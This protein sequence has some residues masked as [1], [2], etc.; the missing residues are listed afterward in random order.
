MNTL[1][2]LNPHQD[3]TPW[4]WA[5]HHHAATT[6]AADSAPR[7][8]RVDAGCLWA[9]ARQEAHRGSAAP[10]DIWLRTGDSLALPAGSEWVLQ[11]WPQAR[12]S[13]LVAA[14]VVLNRG[15]TF[16]SAFFLAFWRR[17]RPA[18]PPRAAVC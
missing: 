12:L 11:G 1:A 10:E 18:S 13:L 5:L 6:L 9:T 8:L 17:L 15:G 2:M 16:F 7:W 14:P 3:S 4:V